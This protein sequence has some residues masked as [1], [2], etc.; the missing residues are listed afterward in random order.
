MPCGLC[1]QVIAEFCKDAPVLV[2]GP[3]GVVR[4]GFAQLLPD[5]F[6]LHEEPG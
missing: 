4:R 2:A 1:R 3:R 6:E 5:A